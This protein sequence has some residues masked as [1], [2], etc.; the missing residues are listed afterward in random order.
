MTRWTRR[1]VMIV[2]GGVG[3]SL[4][5]SPAMTAAR[6]SPAFVSFVGAEGNAN[7]S[8]TTGTFA[9]TSGNVIVVGTAGDASHSVSTVTDTA[10]NSYSRVVDHP[11]YG[12]HEVWLAHTI[13]GH[14]SNAVTVTWSSGVIWGAAVAA[15]QY[16]G[17]S[18]DPTHTTR[19]D[20]FSSGGTSPVTITTGLF[21]T[22]LA[23]AI[24]AHF[25]YNFGSTGGWTA[26]TEYTERGE[27]GG[28]AY[29]MWQDRTVTSTV[30]NVTAS[31][32]VSATN[33]KTMLTI[34]LA[35]GGGGGGS[36]ATPGLLNAPVRGGRS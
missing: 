33:A 34:T 16:S 9:A 15:V 32:T 2:V 8:L 36:S 31:M 19:T 1:L 24:L 18:C 27:T 35:C 6:Q 7:P 21:S 13:T 29:A 23:P 3:I 14:S 26:G 28:N 25:G 11:T 5:T 10:G 20:T 30:T 4:S 22:T 17:L 12:P